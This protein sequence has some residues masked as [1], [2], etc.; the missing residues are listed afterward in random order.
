LRQLVGRAAYTDCGACRSA[1]SASNCNSYTYNSRADDS[2]ERGCSH[3]CSSDCK[4]EHSADESNH[5]PTDQPYWATDADH[6]KGSRGGNREH[7]SADKQRRGSDTDWGSADSDATDSGT[8]QWSAHES[9]A[10]SCPCRA[11]RE[12]VGRDGGE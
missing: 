12:R 2:A 7:S 9:R 5:D 11:M 4:H 6:H 3:A 10:A 1:G 8:G